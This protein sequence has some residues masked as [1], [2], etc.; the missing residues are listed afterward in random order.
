[1][2][3]SVASIWKENITLYHTHTLN[4]MPPGMPLYHPGKADN[5]SSN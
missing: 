2:P 4:P 3:A 1:M 5:D